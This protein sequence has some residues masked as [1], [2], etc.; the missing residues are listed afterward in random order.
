MIGILFL[1]IISLELLIGCEGSC[2]GRGKFIVFE[3][4][5]HSGKSTQAHAIASWLEEECGVKVLRNQEPTKR[6][7]GRVAREVVM[8]RNPSPVLLYEATEYP[9]P[10]T[11]LTRFVELINEIIECLRK[12]QALS[13]LQ[14]QML[15]L[16][17]RCDDVMNVIR[18]ALRNGT[19]VIQDRF[20]LST[21]A[22]GMAAYLSYEDII[23][24]H[25]ESVALLRVKPDLAF[26]LD[27]RAEESLKRLKNNKG[28]ECGKY[29]E[30]IDFLRRTAKAYG[31]LFAAPGCYEFS[32]NITQLNGDRK[33]QE[34]M[35][36]HIK[37]DIESRF[38]DKI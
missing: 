11:R 16:A 28:C 34:E 5:T 22:F 27:I 10:Y 4:L 1:T 2:M 29:E 21:F 19:W 17:D 13:E 14:I 24:L 6:I 20:T 23:K 3:G 7:L 37:E 12:G 9:S 35:T 36:W 25:H 33:T 38:L 31:N 32:S 18:P 8:K 26:F 30:H 15:F